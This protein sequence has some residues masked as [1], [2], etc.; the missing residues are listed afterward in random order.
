MVSNI[1]KYLERFFYE[2]RRSYIVKPMKD[3][4]VFLRLSTSNHHGDE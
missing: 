4:F 3:V 1:Q 2:Y